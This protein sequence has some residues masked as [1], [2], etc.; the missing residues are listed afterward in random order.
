M[1]VKRQK[2]SQGRPRGPQGTKR[3]KR[4]NPRKPE[5]RVK[6]KKPKQTTNRSPREAKRVKKHTH[7]PLRKLDFCHR[8]SAQKKHNSKP[9]KH[10][11]TPKPANLFSVRQDLWAA[12]SQEFFGP[13]LSETHTG[14][15]LAENIGSPITGILGPKKP[16]GPPKRRLK[17]K[18]KNT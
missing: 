15:Q 17:G 7:G 12:R 14:A 5:T 16:P 10:N 9:L 18:K 4:D 1:S 3:K 8:C 13:K 2:I 11:K 6:G